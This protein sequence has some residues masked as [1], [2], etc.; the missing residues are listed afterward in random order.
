MSS[1]M[2]ASF[3]PTLRVKFA[4]LC[5]IANLISSA[6][7]L[8]AQTLP[9]PRSPVRTEELRNNSAPNQALTFEH[10]LQ[11]A[12]TQS[13]DA[14]RAVLNLEIARADRDI[15]TYEND[16]R[17]NLSASIGGSRP[18]RTGPQAQSGPRDQVYNATISMPIYDF[19]RHSARF[20]AANFTV[21]AKALAKEEVEEALKFSVARAYATVLAVERLKKVIKEQVEVSRSR[22]DIVGTNYRKGLR[23]ESDV[24][25]AEVDLGKAN[26]ALQRAKDDVRSARATLALLAGLSTDMVEAPLPEKRA[27]DGNS[28]RWADL[29]SHLPAGKSVAERRLEKEREALQAD[30]SLIDASQRP[31]L[32]GSLSAQRSGAWGQE[33]QELYTGQMQLSWDVPWNG[34]HR[35]EL[36]RLGLR[37]QDNELQVNFIRKVKSDKEAMAK[38]AFK[39]AEEQYVASKQQESLLAKQREL[40]RRRYETGKAT[41]LEVSSSEADLLSAR[42]DLVRLLNAMTIAALDTAEARSVADVS[43]VFN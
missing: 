9:D 40:V 13:L 41:A 8:K 16:P 34:M 37:R 1:R 24:L 4:S 31:T 18:K 2:H 30:Q 20:E 28:E 32:A 29:F 25:A 10:V 38:V 17:G 3:V 43:V 7:C 33:T 39:A 42:L 11:Q 19:G 22:L 12:L 27:L 23:P 35:D 6:P 15:L 14:Q 26:L 21:E 36:R 5:I